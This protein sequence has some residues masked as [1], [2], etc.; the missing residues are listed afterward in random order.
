MGDSQA[1]QRQVVALE[2]EMLRRPG[3]LA[4]ARAYAT[5]EKLRYGT[6][7]ESVRD[8]LLYRLLGSD[9]LGY[10]LWQY[11]TEESCEDLPSTDA[12]SKELFELLRTRQG[13]GGDADFEDNQA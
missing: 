9:G 10:Y 4:E 11:G 6:Y 2:R 12:S 1:C 8:E 13:F 3:V 7:F 5:R